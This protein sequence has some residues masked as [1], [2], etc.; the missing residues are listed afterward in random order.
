PEHAAAPAEVQQPRTG[1]ERLLAQIW[2]D[3]LGVPAVGVTDNF[4]ELGGDSILGIRVVARAKKAGLVISAKDVFRK[5]TIAE[6]ATT[7]VAVAEAA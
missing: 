5:Q 3:V 7:A 1:T 2:S 4:Y 6:L